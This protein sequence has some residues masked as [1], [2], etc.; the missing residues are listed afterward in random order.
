MQTKISTVVKGTFT[1]KSEHLHISGLIILPPLSST[2]SYTFAPSL[3]LQSL[4]LVAA[5]VDGSFVYNHFLQEFES[6]KVQLSFRKGA[7]EFGQLFSE[8]ESLIIMLT[9]PRTNVASLW[10]PAP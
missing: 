2:G 9:A 1:S 5:A 8:R 6:I 4:A 7:R 3:P 10:P